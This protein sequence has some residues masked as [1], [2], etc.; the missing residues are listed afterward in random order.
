[1]TRDDIPDLILSCM[2]DC[3]ECDTTFDHVFKAPE[4]VHEVEDLVEAPEEEV[5]CPGCGDV[6][7]REWQ[8]WMAHEDAG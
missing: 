3:E 7:V 5:T 2:F 8:G 6:Q 1:M 4:G